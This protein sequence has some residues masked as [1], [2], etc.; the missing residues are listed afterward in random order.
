MTILSRNIVEKFIVTL[1]AKFFKCATRFL[2][3]EIWILISLSLIL[4]DQL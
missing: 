1:K 4:F 2:Y 3:V